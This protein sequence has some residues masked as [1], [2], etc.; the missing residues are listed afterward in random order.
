MLW[1][2]P[3]P[4]SRWAVIAVWEPHEKEPSMEEIAKSVFQVHAI[5]ATGMVVVRRQLKR[6]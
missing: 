6:G 5:S 1:T 2:A 3:A 4:A